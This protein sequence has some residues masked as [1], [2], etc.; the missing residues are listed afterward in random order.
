MRDARYEI[1]GFLAYGTDE[2]R[3]GA[4]LVGN[5]GCAIRDHGL[6]EVC[7]W[8]LAI[9]SREDCFHVLE[10]IVV[11]LELCAH[12]GSGDFARDVIMCGT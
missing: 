6:A 5:D 1:N 4:E 11:L 10:D 2:S 7:L 9:A 12:D 3:C 8:H